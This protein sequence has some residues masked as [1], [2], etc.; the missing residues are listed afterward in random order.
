MRLQNQMITKVGG[1]RVDRTFT[2]YTYFLLEI[3]R[4]FGLINLIKKEDQ[5]VTKIELIL[6]QTLIVPENNMAS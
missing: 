5:M 4:R 2:E 3:M 1:F 6:T